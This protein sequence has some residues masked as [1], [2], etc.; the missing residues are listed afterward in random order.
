MVGRAFRCRGAALVRH[1]RHPAAG[2][3]A[4][5]LTGPEALVGILRNRAQF[6]AVELD[7]DLQALP[8]G[9]AALDRIAGDAAGDRAEYGTDGAAPAAAADIAAG[10]AAD[11]AAGYRADAALGAFDGHLAHAFNHAHAYRLLLPRLAAGIDTAGTAAGAAGDKRR[12]DDRPRDHRS[13]VNLHGSFL[14]PNC[15]LK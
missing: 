14:Y 15:A 2:E 12:R 1:P 6:A 11:R 3:Q 8:L 9:R 13:I 4:H 10:H 5:A 7:R